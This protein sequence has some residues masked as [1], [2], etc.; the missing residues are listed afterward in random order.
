M[1]IHYLQHVSFEGLG[2][3]EDWAKEQGHSIKATKFFEKFVLPELASF[4]LLVVLGGPMGVSDVALHPWLLEEK[5][6]IKSAI[7]ADKLVVGICLGAQ[8]IAECL[9]AKVYANPQKEI[10]WFPIEKTGHFFF[11]SLPA[12][13]D[14]FHWHGDTFDIP[15]QAVHLASSAAFRNQAFLYKKRVLALQ[16]HLEIKAGGIQAL[17]E[18]AKAELQKAD[19]VQE[20]AA[21]LNGAKHCEANNIA[22]GKLLNWLGK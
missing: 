21:L 11:K 15:R 22:L 2:S 3:I 18:N 17:I 16:F 14:A 1:R 9:G 10:G 6:L 4:D 5:A 20:E 19:F 13:F 12:A 8:L 7:E